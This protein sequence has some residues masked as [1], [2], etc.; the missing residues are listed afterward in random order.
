QITP[1]ARIIDTDSDINVVL[2]SIT[3]LVTG[4]PLWWGFWRRIQLIRSAQ[5]ESEL[6]SRARRAYLALL[7]GVGGVTALISLVVA[8][9]RFIEDLLDGN[10]GGGTFNDI[11]PALALVLTTGAIAGYH[12]VV[13]KED[14]ADTPAAI[15]SPLREVI[16]LGITAPGAMAALAEQ[17]DVRVRFWDRIDEVPAPLDVSSLAAEL[18]DVSEERVL[19]MAT[20]GG[21]E[22]VPFAERR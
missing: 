19:V 1:S 16:L 7:F 5:P 14:R 12:W 17:L 3:L 9:F 11:A 10:L 22:I 13:F 20:P 18:A 2:G 15:A 8:V 4:G 6:R 21:Y